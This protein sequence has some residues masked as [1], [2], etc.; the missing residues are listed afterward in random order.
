MKKNFVWAVVDCVQGTPYYYKCRN[1]VSALCTYAWH[2][3]TKKKYGTMNFTLKQE[4]SPHRHKW[5]ND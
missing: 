3:L 4:F 5:R 2:Y 1:L